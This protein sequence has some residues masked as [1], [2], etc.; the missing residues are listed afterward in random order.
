LPSWSRSKV[1][2]VANINELLDNLAIFFPFA[3]ATSHSP[4]HVA[5]ADNVFKN[6]R[7]CLRV[8]EGPVALAA[9]RALDEV[10]MI[11]CI[12]NATH[13][14]FFEAAGLEEEFKHTMRTIQDAIAMS[15]LQYPE[16][17][18][19]VMEDMMHLTDNTRSRLKHAHVIQKRFLRHVAQH[20]SRTGAEWAD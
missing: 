13:E 8:Q 12:D 16:T 3:L 1:I 9:A 4:D 7:H 11:T 20:L 15:M 18:E 19:F 17:Y 14:A 6:I 5:A 2:A 10:G